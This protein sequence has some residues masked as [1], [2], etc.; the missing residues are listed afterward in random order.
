M[1]ISYKD[2]ST[3]R[4]VKENVVSGSNKTLDQAARR[5]RDHTTYLLKDALGLN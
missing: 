1:R 3:G 2:K 4:L 5:Q